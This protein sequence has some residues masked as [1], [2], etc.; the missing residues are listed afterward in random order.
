MRLRLWGSPTGR[1]RALP[2][3]LQNRQ[4]RLYGRLPRTRFGLVGA[5]R[6]SRPP[7]LVF[8]GLPALELKL[9]GWP[10][11]DGK[12]VVVAEFDPCPLPKLFAVRTRSIT[13]S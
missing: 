3:E 5:L 7:A 4:Y 8:Q 13:G 6:V 9:E 12:Q 2:P 11:S 1:R 10:E